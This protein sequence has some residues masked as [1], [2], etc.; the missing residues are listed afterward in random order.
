MQALP[1]RLDRTVII[2]AT[3]DTVFRFFTD[4]PRW[5]AWWG[6]GSTIDARPGGAI[7]IRHPDGTEVTGVVEEL[8]APERIVFTYG[9]VKGTPIPAGGS[10]VAIA[11]HPDH[12]GTRLDLVHEFAEPIARDEFVQGWR[13]QLS[14]F[15]NVV[16]D[17]AN[18]NASETVDA[19]FDVWAEP[20]VAARNRTLTR[21][22][23]PDV[24]FHDRYSNLDGQADI[25][26]H[27]GAAQRFMPGIRLHRDGA[28][29]H[30]QGIVLSDWVARN[31]DGKD[32]M[33]GTNVF[34]L[35]PRGQIESVTGVVTPGAAR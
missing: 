21:I 8:R 27:I 30:C 35:N 26:A 24:Q 29:R 18:A 7:Y 22:A 20:D 14:L 6:K 11:L 13:F 32:L 17:E 34:V 1:H 33:R 19:W 2:R 31:A 15:A 25:T 28:V 10:R 23:G 16:A 9:F 12:A 5:A 4:T 3:P